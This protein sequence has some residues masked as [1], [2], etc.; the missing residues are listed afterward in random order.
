MAQ[1][2]KALATQ[3]LGPEFNPPNLSKGGSKTDP[4]QLS[5]D[6]HIS[7]TVCALPNKYTPSASVDNNTEIIRNSDCSLCT[8]IVILYMCEMFMWYMCVCAHACGCVPTGVWRLRADS[9]Y[10]P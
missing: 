8:F 5:S 7:S 9:R 6:L 10:L 1:L 4:T 3:A 2:V